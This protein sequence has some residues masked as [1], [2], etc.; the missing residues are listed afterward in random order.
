MPV[1]GKAL[2]NTTSHNDDKICYNTSWIYNAYFSR[3]MCVLIKTEQLA[4]AYAW[5]GVLQYNL[6]DWLVVLG[7]TAL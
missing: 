4:H 7:L 1:L 6:T 5:E 2:Y 3:Y